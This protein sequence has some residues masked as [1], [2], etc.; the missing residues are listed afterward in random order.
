VD[1]CTS[2]E[3][4]HSEQ[5]NPVPNTYL[6]TFARFLHHASDASLG[7]D[8]QSR[9]TE[10]GPS[11]GGVQTCYHGFRTNSES[12]YAPRLA[13]SPVMCFKANHAAQDPGKGRKDMQKWAVR[14]VCIMRSP[15]C[16][17]AARK[18]CSRVLLPCSD[19]S[20]VVHMALNTGLNL[21]VLLTGFAQ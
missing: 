10:G 17:W 15:F 13:M 1:P 16:I 12:F 21:P 14:R 4:P 7:P 20:H 6:L 2:C 3:Q 5:S 11:N 9:D 19:G 8:S 18:F